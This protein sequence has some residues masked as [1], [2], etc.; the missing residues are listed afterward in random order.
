MSASTKKSRIHLS[1][2]HIGDA[3][4][5]YVQEAFKTNWIAP[6]GPHVDA[7]ERDF[8]TRF[9]FKHAAALS[10]GT[11][12]LHLSIRLLK[13][14]PGDE[15]V[16]SSLTFAA[17]ANPIIYEQARPVFVDSDEESWNMNAGLL[18]GWLESRARIGR[19]PKAVI[20]VDLYG[21]C[22]NLPRIAAACRK[23]GVPIIEDAAEALGAMCGGRPAG[24]YGKLGMFSFNGNK[25]ITTSGGGMLVS[26]DGEMIAHARFLATQARDPAPHYQH[27]ELGFN[28]RMSNVL[29]GIGRGQLQ[30]LDSRVE[31]RRRV[32]S[33]YYEALHELPGVEFMPEPEYSRSNRWLTCLTIDPVRAGVDREAVRLALDAENIESR[34]VW[35]PLHLQPVFA[36]CE[37]VG[38]AVS[39]RLFNQGLCLPS[40]SSLTEAEQDRVIEMVRATFPQRVFQPGFE[41]A[42]APAR[43]DAAFSFFGMLGDFV[44]RR[45]I[46]GMQ[47]FLHWGDRHLG[48]NAA[49]RFASI[50]SIYTLNLAA[51][52]WLAYEM[53]WDF[54]VPLA[55]QEQR[56][57]LVV[58]VVLCKLWLLRSFGQFRS[59]L[60]YFGLSDFGAVALSM[61][62]VSVIMLGLWYGSE[63]MAA[64]PRGVI[65]MD[66]VLSVALISAFRLSLRVARSLCIAAGPAASG[67]TYRR[68]AIVGAGDAGEALAKD[69]L[70]RRSSGLLPVLFVDDDP[71]RI[72]RSIHGLPVYGPVDRLA[73]LMPGARIH[74]LIITTSGLTAKRIREIVELG[75][76]I[77]ATTQI[78][79]SI[80]QLATGEV[81]IERSRP[82]AI[83]DLLG[84]PP[85]NLKSSDVAQLIYGR[86][87]LVTGA[88]GSIGSELCRQI[89]AQKPRQLVILDQAELG[90][91][92][93]EQ[94]LI[95]Q[96]HGN[97]LKPLIVD[98]GDAV[99]MEE[100]FSRFRPEI[101]FHAAAHKHVPLMELQPKEAVK[102]N[103]LATDLLTR[104]ASK[105]GVERFVLISTDKA[106]NPTSVMGCSKR[107]AEKAMLVRQR[108]PGNR[109]AFL[110]VRFGNV[111]GSSGS[112][113][114]TFRKQIAQGGPVTVTHP[115][116]TRYFMTIPEAVGLVL[117]TATLGEGGEIF[118]LDMG[119][120]VK[121]LDMA[122]QMI[123]LS[124]YRP[125][126]DIEVRITGMRPGEKLFEEL[127]HDEETHSPTEHPRIFRLKSEKAPEHMDECLADLRAAAHSGT[128]QAIKQTMQRWVPEYTPFTEKL[129]QPDGSGGRSPA[130]AQTE[131]RPVLVPGAEPVPVRA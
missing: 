82:V 127:C 70:Q 23:H 131:P 30:V 28:Y 55:F 72:G 103:T 11:A 61:T 78:V 124:G 36:G 22:A 67:S 35:K 109:T 53:R 86:V 130:S 25:I 63:T 68:A 45:A 97:M 6:V 44:R 18:E 98:V 50:L 58:V 113:V 69:L 89:A 128:P 5:G 116:M 3:E 16:C 99:A 108:A 46:G 4:L 75:R 87:V 19:L 121:I 12:A 62:S 29:A 93:I 73:K 14:R 21:Q 7:F 64:P 129:E 41:P 123:E 20:V 88:G 90:V 106:I 117:Q 39:E 65:L 119:Q 27:S 33:R 114:A 57:Q 107:L 118:I 84:R 1:P 54:D 94:E 17:S 2:P 47:A 60:S 77:G 38:G 101:V 102:N 43:E 56:L 31:A 71:V 40:G 126:V 120:P 92:E 34:P 76:S 81:K 9:G 83:E 112:V 32:F 24:S 79:P 52:F 122:R 96:G 115:E 91:F 37:T 66:F 110:A 80:S 74:E 104:L 26:E 125:D 95:R 100:V 8:C 105:H 51:V 48:K 13:L 10:S 15:V 42:V 59:V 111:L 85:V 49:M